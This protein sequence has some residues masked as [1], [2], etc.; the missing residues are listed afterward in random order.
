MTETANKNAIKH[1]A[2][3]ENKDTHDLKSS[4]GLIL[5]HLRYI[6]KSEKGLSF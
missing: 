1:K 4:C 6:F 3:T 2:L 5:I